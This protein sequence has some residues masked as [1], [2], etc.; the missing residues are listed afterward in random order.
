MLRDTNDVNA[1]FL[2]LMLNPFNVDDSKGTD[3]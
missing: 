2:V 1:G 3:A